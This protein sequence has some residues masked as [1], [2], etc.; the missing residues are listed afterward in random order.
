MAEERDK[1][2]VLVRIVTNCEHP[3]DLES[4]FM[5]EKW[6]VTLWLS[7]ILGRR[8][9]HKNEERRKRT[10]IRSL[11]LVVHLHR[12][13]SAI[14]NTDGILGTGTIVEDRRVEGAG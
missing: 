1:N 8:R 4:L 14:N 11:T 3:L 10:L 13:A 6:P 9:M 5:H 7:A 2:N 12:Q